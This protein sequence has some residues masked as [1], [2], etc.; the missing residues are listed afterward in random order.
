MRSHAL[1]STLACL[2]LVWIPGRAGEVAA[3]VDPAT[4]KA[5]L[6]A[7]ADEAAA[8]REAGRAT[9]RG[10]G[11]W[12]FLTAEL[13]HLG[14]GPFWG[15]HA[16]EAG[17]ASKPEW[18]DPLPVIVDI[19]RQLADLDIDLLLVPVPPR[20]VLYADK[21]G[22]E[23][24]TDE[25]GLP[26]RIDVHHRRF[27]ALLREEGVEVLDLTDCLLAARADEVEQGPVCCMQDSHWSSRGC[28]LAA[29]AVGRAI[30]GRDWFAALERR[31]YPTGRREQAITGDLVELYTGELE[32]ATETLV[33]HTVGE[34]D[35]GAP[36]SADSPIVLLA[37]SHGLVF[38]TGGK[39]L[40]ARGAG[41][42]DHLA[43]VCGSPVDLQAKRGGATT[44]LLALVRAFYRE[45]DYRKG[46]RLIVW[47][48]A[49]REF[50][51][52]GNGWRKFPLTPPQ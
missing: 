18:R 14:A 45:A 15:E 42:A 20:A 47:C 51:E 7:C 36:S 50:T 37:D 16:A 28:A 30:A 11:E 39:G 48:F 1:V 31:E 52:N 29:E 38:H 25:R 19:H 17:T 32:T 8:A 10:E 22:I 6:A 13:R 3:A 34:D 23:V 21:L 49:A 26:R 44:A 5:F 24:P 41:L 2:L 12:L 40:H 43:R 33:L 9:L 4:A 27:Y 46:K 35:R